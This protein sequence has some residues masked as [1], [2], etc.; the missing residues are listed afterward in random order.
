[1]ERVIASNGKSNYHIVTSHMPD[2]AVCFAAATLKEYLYKATNANILYFADLERCPRVGPEIHVGLNVRSDKVDVSKLSNDGFIIKTD[3]EDIIITGKT[4]R[5]TVYGVYYFLERFI[6]FK[7]FTKDVETFDKKDT[8]VVEDLNIIENPAFSYR[9][10][11]L[12]PAFDTKFCVKNR[13]NANMAHIPNEMGGRLK[14]F[15]CHHSFSDLVP[16]EIYFDTNPEYFSMVNG[17]RVRNQPQLCLT[18]EGTY[19]VALNTLRKWIKQNPNCKVFSVSQ[20]D[21]EN[22]CTCTECKKLDDKHGGPSGSLINFVNKLAREIKKDYP[23]V[24]IHTLA[25]MYTRRAPT[26]IK[27][28]DNVIIRLCSFECRWDAPMTALAAANPN[29]EAAKFLEN[30]ENWSKI[31]KHLYI[32]DYSSNFSNYLMPFPNYKTMPANLRTY[33][34][35]NVDGVM[36][37]GNF[38]YGELTGLADLQCYLGAKLL[39]NPNLDENEIIDDFI[40]GVYGKECHPYIREYVSLLCESVK[41]KKLSIYQHPSADF[42]TDSLVEKAE[43]LFS[44]AFAVVKGE[45]SK[46]YLK[47]EYLS[48]LFLK[49]SRMELENEQRNALIDKLYS[50]VKEFGITE[51][52]ERRPLDICFENLRNSRYGLSRDNEYVLYYIMK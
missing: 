8:L 51:I 27:V 28:E 18:N 33:K 21:W 39:W 32:W 48:V 47:K 40:K 35:K 12:R 20:N 5:G 24:L 6:N 38:S 41:G 43:Q 25:Y 13:L 16:P 17:K 11:Y 14:F 30:I 29:G 4:P 49:A 36:Q 10:M 31:C 15:N 52:R 1:M 50:G 22:N 46:W 44:K 7:C 2:D 45:K 23:D 34:E 26:G 37:Q 42:V 9:E 19:Q 3:N